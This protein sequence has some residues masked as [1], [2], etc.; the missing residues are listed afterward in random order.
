MRCSAD[1]LNTTMASTFDVAFGISA[2]HARFNVCFSCLLGCEMVVTQCSKQL[3]V[4]Q[5]LAP[6]LHALNTS[7]QHCTNRQDPSSLNNSNSFN[8]F[9]LVGGCLGCTLEATCSPGSNKTNLLPRRCISAHC[10]CMT[11][12]LVVSSSV[13]VL[14]RVHS[15]TTNLGP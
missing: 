8:L 6:V 3:H 5:Q 12:M 11:N 13:R 4:H 9:L 2:H 14:H 10:G 15:H 7:I 1:S